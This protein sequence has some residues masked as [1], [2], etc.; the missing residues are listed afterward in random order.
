MATEGKKEKKDKGGNPGASG[1]GEGGAFKR[2]IAKV[3]ESTGSQ[4]INDFTRP[5][6]EK[7]PLGI[8]QALGRMQVHKVLSPTAVIID[9]LLPK[10]SIWGDQLGN[11]LNEFSSELRQRISKIME[12][13]ESAEGKITVDKKAVI[14]ATKTIFK[15]LFSSEIAGDLEANLKTLD[16]IMSGRS[17]KEQAVIYDILG[18]MPER[19]LAWFFDQFSDATKDQLNLF[20]IRFIKP[21]VVKSDKTFK[22]LVGELRQDIREFGSGS[23]ELKE[24]GQE[25]WKVVLSPIW[26]AA[27]GWFAEDGLIHKPIVALRENHTTPFREKMRELREAK[28]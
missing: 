13:E 23:N 26:E 21:D 17:D 7:I 28:R 4:A 6:V 24:L 19:D 20:F 5:I 9:S 27:Y 2:A 15:V 22:Q 8:I 12:G 1:K 18:S 25:I 11:A 3:A 14:G 16:N 10:N